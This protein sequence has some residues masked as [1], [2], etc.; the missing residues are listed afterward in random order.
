MLKRQKPLQMKLHCNI[1]N[2]YYDKTDDQKKKISS[3]QN[4]EQQQSIRITSKYMFV[5]PSIE[6]GIFLI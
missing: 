2:I 4:D 1:Y 3:S 6:I 5:F